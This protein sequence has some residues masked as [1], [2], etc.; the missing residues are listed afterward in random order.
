MPIFIFLLALENDLRELE[1]SWP[2]IVNFYYKKI[3][4]V[5]IFK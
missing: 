2:F 3:I 4:L 1:T 5:Y